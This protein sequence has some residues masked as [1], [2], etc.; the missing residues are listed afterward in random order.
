MFTSIHKRS[1]AEWAASTYRMNAIYEL[2]GYL[3]VDIHIVDI[4]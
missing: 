4:G 3:L 1:C 2:Y